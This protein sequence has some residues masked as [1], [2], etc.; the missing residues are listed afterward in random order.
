MSKTIFANDLK[1]LS[2]VKN[3]QITKNANFWSPETTQSYREGQRYAAEF[4]DLLRKYPHTASANLLARTLLDMASDLK[5]KSPTALGFIGLI[6]HILVNTDVSAKSISELVR[7]FVESDNLSKNIISDLSDLESSDAGVEKCY[8]RLEMSKILG[9]TP[10]RLKSLL[11]SLNW[12][13]VS[14]GGATKQSLRDGFM[15][16]DTSSDN[17]KP[18]VTEKGLAMLKKVAFK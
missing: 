2:F 17:I 3:I 1:K 12:I 15:K 7:Q 5:Q 6:E 4:A 10:Y 18:V 8:G 13:K 14:D 16:L 9:I 11:E